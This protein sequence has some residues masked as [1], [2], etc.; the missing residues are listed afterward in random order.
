[1]TQKASLSITDNRTRK[2]YEIPISHN[3][4]HAPHFKQITAPDADTGLLISDPGLR[5]TA[6]VESEVAYLNGSTGTLHYRS[7]SVGELYHKDLQYEDVLHLLTWGY[8]PSQTQKAQL[9]T[10][11]AAALSTPADTIFSV[12]HAF[13]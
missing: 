13:P 3:A 10:E 2:T 7:Y 12:I 5:N 6:V 11:L 9:R 4:I 1:M 8:L